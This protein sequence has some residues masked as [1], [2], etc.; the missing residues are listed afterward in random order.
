MSRITSGAQV[1]PNIWDHP[2]LYELENRATD[3]DG[4]IESAMRSLRT[5]RDAT[6]LDLGCGTGY[7]LP[8]FATEAAK[9]VGV[10]PHGD[11]VTW[12]RLRTRRLP[13]VEVVRGSAQRIPVEAASIDVVHARWAYFF[14]P[15]CEPGLLELARVVRRGGVAFVVDTDATQSTFGRWF[16]RALPAYD[17]RAVDEFFSLHGWSVLR[18]DIR[19]MFDTRADLEAVVRIEFAPDHAERILAEHQSLEVDY[20]I[21]LRVRHY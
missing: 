21:N 16:S 20:A 9:V 13:N 12:A 7:H 14:G 15:G 2:H 10:E 18:L 11:L 17:A 5:W 19:W 8:L 6:V 1:S 4:V 3:P